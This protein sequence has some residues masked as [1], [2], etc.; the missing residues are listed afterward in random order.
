MQDFW[1]CNMTLW[2]DKLGQISLAITTILWGMAAVMQFIVLDWAQEDLG[3]TLQE[4]FR[5]QAVVGI[6][7][8]I[9]AVLASRYVAMR[10]ATAV[11]PLG[12]VIGSMLLQAV[13][14]YISRKENPNEKQK[15]E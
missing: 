13:A 6:G 10:R 3:Q 8:T 7:S 1:H 5:M 15:H 11:I 4:S 9:G 2:R 14:L 12:M